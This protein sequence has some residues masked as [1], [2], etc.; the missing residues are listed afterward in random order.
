TSTPRPSSSSIAALRSVVNA[1]LRTS[2]TTATRSVALPASSASE[3]SMPG[4]RLSMTYQPRSSSALA[5]V[6]R[7]A[8]DMPVITTNDGCLVVISAHRPCR[9]MRRP[10]RGARRGAPG[11]RPPRAW[12]GARSRL[13]APQRADDR[14]GGRRPDAGNGTDLLLGRVA[15]PL[16]RAEMAQQ[17]L[18]TR[19]SQA[20]DP[21]ERALLQR[22]RPLGPM[23]GDGETVRLVA[24]PL[25]QVKPL[26]AAR[27]DHR[28]VLARQPHLLQPLGQ[29]ADRHVVDAELVERALRGRRL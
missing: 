11:P 10:A 21:V 2:T 23:V 12:P 5:A 3:E 27:Q 1:R 14:L 6:L 4:G 28:V 13:L 15:Q 9:W 8:P 18:P 25:E 26:A 16:Q 17:R 19:R 29:A 20:R 22:L 24:D 7:P